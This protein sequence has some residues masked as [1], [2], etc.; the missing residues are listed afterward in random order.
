MTL[1]KEVSQ[2]DGAVRLANYET[3]KVCSYAVYLMPGVQ[4]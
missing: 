2:Q 4:E 3:H 1:S